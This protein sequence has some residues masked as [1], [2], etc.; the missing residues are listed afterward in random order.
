MDKKDI[1]KLEDLGYV[2]DSLKVRTNLIESLNQLGHTEKNLE[3][4]KKELAIIKKTGK[5][6]GLFIRE[7]LVKKNYTVQE[8]IQIAENNKKL[9]VHKSLSKLPKKD[10]I[11][12][13]KI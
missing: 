1:K 10:N 11:K 12:R 3:S 4:M 5:K 13:L 8:A 9:A 6:Q 7:D 2:A